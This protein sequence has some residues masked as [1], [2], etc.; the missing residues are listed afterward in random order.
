MDDTEV[1]QVYIKFI[2]GPVYLRQRVCE[3]EACEDKELSISKHATHSKSS[4]SSSNKLLI[5]SAKSGTVREILIKVGQI[6]TLGSPLLRVSVCKHPTMLG[7]TCGDCGITF[8]EDDDEEEDSSAREPGRANIQPKTVSMLHSMPNLRVTVEEAERLGAADRAHLLEKHKLVLLVDLDQTLL[9]TTNDNVPHNIKDV[10]HFRLH[11][12]SPVYHC[13]LRPYTRKFLAR[14][15]ELYELHICTFGVREYA[16]VIA[17]FLDPDGKLFQQ[18]IL[19]RNECLDPMSK[20]ANL[21]SLFPCGDELVCIMDDRSDVWHFAPNV[22]QVL[23][24]HFFQ[25]T[26]DINAPPGLQK[27]ENDQQHKGFDFSA[28]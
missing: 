7:N 6:V 5:K 19:S 17:H 12:H 24:Y 18:R 9:H 25:H 26:G 23:P 13:R 21:K 1:L 10:H 14:M 27:K 20:K 11:P 16:H 3:L 28:L 4:S 22:V 2:G 15:S 8:E